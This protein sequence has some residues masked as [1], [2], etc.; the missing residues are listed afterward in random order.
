MAGQAWTGQVE[1]IDPDGTLFYWELVQAPAGVTLTPPTDILSADD[2]YHAIA[3]LNWTPSA[4]DP[5]N[6]EIIVRVQDSRGGVAT[7]R[8]Q[9]SVIGGNNTPVVDVISDINLKEGE[10]LSLPIIAADADGDALTLIIRNLPAGA[11]FDA[12][13]GILSWTPGYDQA[14]IYQNITVVA[15]DGKTTVSQHFNLTVEQG[16]A[17]PVL[18]SVMQQTLR[19]GDRYALQLAGH[20]AGS[21]ALADGTTVTLEYSA[22]WL[23]GGAKLNT[24]TGW[25]E[26]TPDYNQHGMFRIPVTLT[27]VWNAPGSDPVL[28]SV[29]KDVV[30]NVL[31]AN[32]T[33]VFDASSSLSKGSAETWNILEGQPLQI[34]AF[35]FDPDN[36]DFEPRI[37]LQADAVASG[38]ET[39][40]ATVSYQVSGLPEGARFDPDTLEILWTPGFSQAGTYSIIV[41]VTDDGDGTGVPA[42]SQLVLPIVVGNAN[43]APD[44]GDIS[45]AFVDKGSVIEIPVSAVDADDNPIQIS[46]SGLPRFATYTQ[47]PSKGNGTTTGV[48]RFAPGANDRGDYT[49]TVVAQDNGDPLRLDLGQASIGSGQAANNNVLTQ[50]KS[51]VLTVRSE[52]EAPVITAPRQVVAVVGQPLSVALLANDMD[53]DVLTWS[54]NGLPVGAE[55]IAAIQY[56]HATLTWTPTAGDIGSRDLELV[57]TDSGLAPENAGYVQPANPVSNVTKHTVRVVVRAANIAPELLGVQVNGSQIAD[58]GATTPIQLN[59]SE[60]VPLTLELFGRDTDADLIE[61]AATGLPRGMTLDVPSASNGNLAVLRWTQDMFTAQDSNTGTAGQWRYTVRGSDG[62]AQFERSFEVNVANVNQTPRLLPMPLQLVNEGQTVNFTMSSFDA[63]NDAVSMGL[64]YDSTTPSGVVFDGVTGYFEWTPDQSI[65]NGAIENN[66]PY[67]FT[68]RATDGSATTTQAV[69]VRVFDVNRSPQLTATNHALVIGQTLSLPVE[70]G[71]TTNN[72]ITATDPDGAEQTAA[73]VISFVNLP[74]GASYDVQARRLNWVPGPGQIG[75]FTVT[76]KA[77]DGKNTTSRTFTLRVVAEASA[78]QPKIV[79]STTPSTPV[80]PGQTIVTS[81]RADAWSGIASIVTEVRG[82][83]LGDAD[84]WQTA[85]LDNAGRMKLLPTQPGLIEVRVT[86]TDHDGFV[87]SQTHTVRIKNP[88]DTTAPLLAWV[89]ELSGASAFTKPVEIN[90]VTVLKAGLTEQQLMGYK[91]QIAPAGSDIGTLRVPLRKWYAQRTLLTDVW[92]TLAEHQ[93]AAISIDQQLDLIDLDPCQIRQ[94][95]LPVAPV[96]L[97]SRRPHYR[98]RSTNHHRHRAKRPGQTD[99][100]R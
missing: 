9:L 49:V 71:T 90:Q 38:P 23:P 34:S 96:S 87:S 24:E 11:V 1:A 89:D 73:L 28:T 66:H 68:F 31:N 33:P 35:A 77:S 61:W 60:G 8:F 93:D 20:V 6:T 79:V 36:P 25:L 10:A 46:I 29:T 16:Y 56:G 65:V 91:L 3:T 7:R 78:N 44:I 40:A 69:Q 45:N 74:E 75:D 5:A 18:G 12:A 14:G 48:I 54:A 62:T 76:A 21:E 72:G 4:R 80:L 97:G 86:A 59:A 85:I 2:G 95:R 58:T 15:S 32:G 70:L 84:T 13:S 37:R 99:R 92:Q 27:A 50:A 43:R 39:T 26:W 64:V 63:D 94:W 67:T 41:T 100:Y 55:I 17:K 57:V 22:P 82:S 42:V 52:T 47:N 51:F 98:N 81:V 19:E 53:Q 83:G 30:L 88:A